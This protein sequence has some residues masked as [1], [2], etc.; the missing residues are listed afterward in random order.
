M[1]SLL[2]SALSENKS[3]KTMVKA[4][5][6]KNMGFTG[7][8]CNQL[9]VEIRDEKSFR[10]H[11]LLHQ[12]QSDGTLCISTKLL[13]DTYPLSIQKYK[14]VNKNTWITCFAFPQNCF[15]YLYTNSK[16]PIKIPCVAFPQNC[17]LIP[18]PLSIHKYKYTNTM[19]FHKTAASLLPV[20]WCTPATPSRWKNPP[21][22]WSHIFLLDSLPA[23]ISL[24]LSKQCSHF[25][26]LL[27]GIMVV[28]TWVSS[29][30]DLNP[31]P[32]LIW[33]NKKTVTLCSLM[34][35]SGHLCI[36]LPVFFN[37][38]FQLRTLSQI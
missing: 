9:D 20:L 21:K 37:M 36:G 22:K 24:F 26:D 14:Y 38:T 17:C 29:W 35:Y 1:P 2:G 30:S 27:S 28:E 8:G 33:R 3:M 16:I 4:M 23:L 6:Q 19:H 12:R 32:I 25:L 18:Y 11:F 31:E 7:W 10:I 34:I 15:H 5:L 13:S